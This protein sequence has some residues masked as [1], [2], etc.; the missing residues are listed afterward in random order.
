MTIE[1]RMLMI[2]LLEQMKENK[3][4]ADELGLKDVSKFKGEPISQEEND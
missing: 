4:F 1:E 2:E 3:K